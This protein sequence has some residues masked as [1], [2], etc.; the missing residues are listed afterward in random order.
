MT[1]KMMTE[2]TLADRL[3]QIIKEQKLTKKAFAAKLSI[4][5]NYVYLLTGKSKNRPE[6][7]ANSLAR[8]IALEFGYDEDWIL[9]GEERSVARHL[10]GEDD[11][12]S[13]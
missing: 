2:T 10:S 11:I 4:T 13:R 7:I 12:S 6:T 8:L 5:E 3:N 1:I 9:F